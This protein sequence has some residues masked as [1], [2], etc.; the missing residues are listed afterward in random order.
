[1]VT[2]KTS[3]VSRYCFLKVS[4]SSRSKYNSRFTFSAAKPVHTHL[5]GSNLQTARCT[6]CRLMFPVKRKGK[7]AAVTFVF[8]KTPDIVLQ[9]VIIH[10]LYVLPLIFSYTSVCVIIS[11]FS[12]PVFIPSLMLLLWI[13]VLPD[14]HTSQCSSS[15]CFY[16]T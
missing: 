13:F 16:F 10:L 9:R 4:D 3:F 2:I 15:G 6:A 14:L 12:N 5:W 1:M 8:S 7:A 11:S